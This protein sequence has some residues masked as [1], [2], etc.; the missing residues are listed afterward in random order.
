[1]ATAAGERTR[2]RILDTAE[3]LILEQGYAATS[4][5]QIIA[6][7]KMTKGSFFYHFKKK[8]DLALAL[9]RRYAAADAKLLEENL[10]RAEKLGNDPLQQILIFIGLFLETAD[11]LEEP[12]GC[13]FASYC[14]E[15]GLFDASIHGVVAG[16]I[17]EWRG[18]LGEKL[19]AAAEKHP[20][21]VPVDLDALADMLTVVF[22]GSFIL[23]RTLKAPA[24]FA[25]Q[26]R[27][28]RTYLE[29]LFGQA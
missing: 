6:K 11:A 10:R 1:M 24:I 14:Y 12:P 21:R 8:D 9:I 17:L 19:R 18:K 4:V 26:L 27:L 23:S 2:A 22:E 29:I 5:D 20:P 28:Y 13:L 7:L 15:S 25:A 16:A 3:A